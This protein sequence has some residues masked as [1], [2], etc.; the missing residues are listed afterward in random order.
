MPGKDGLEMIRELRQRYPLGKIIAFS[1]GGRRG[2][3]DYLKLA[4][5]LGAERVLAKPFS[6]R[7]ILAVISQVLLGH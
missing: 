2:G 4:K 6:D 3:Q 1:G 7:E 5:A